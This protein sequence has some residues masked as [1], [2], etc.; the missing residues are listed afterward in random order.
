MREKVLFIAKPN[1]YTKNIF[2]DLIEY[3]NV[4]LSNVNENMVKETLEL[5]Y[6][7]VIILFRETQGTS[8]E[9]II[10]LE[11][12]LFNEIKDRIKERIIKLKEVSI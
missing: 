4:Q 6:P 7:E 3:F 9:N 10:E 12:N 2:S 5:F 1:I 8:E 11:Y